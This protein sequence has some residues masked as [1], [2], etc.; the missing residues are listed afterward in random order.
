MR[1]FGRF[2]A[3]TLV[4]LLVV[5]AI[6]G[7]LIG[8]LLPAVQ[9]AREAARRSHCASNLKQ[10]GL[11]LHNYADANRTLC[12]KQGGTGTGEPNFPPPPPQLQ[13][14][15]ECRSGWTSLSVYME[16]SALYNMM[17]RPYD[18]NGDGTMDYMAFG[19]YPWTSSHPGNTLIYVPWVTQIPTI[20]CP[21]DS[22][23]P[24]GSSSVAWTSYAFCCGDTVNDNNAG[25]LRGAFGSFAATT[26]FADI[27][28][29]TSSTLAFG[30]RCVG[31]DP[32]YLASG[33][34]VKSRVSAPWVATDPPI[35]CLN[36]RGAG[37][38]L[39]NFRSNNY[40]GRWWADGR[41][42]MNGFCTILAPN[43]PS[44][45]RSINQNFNWGVYTAGSYH[46][47]GC[48]VALC[49][50]SVRFISETIDTGRIDL[51]PPPNAG[52]GPSPY[53]VWGALGTKNGSEV[54]SDF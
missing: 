25:T 16:Q 14:N 27:V 1:T 9:A 24:A 28:D 6:I 15:W 41:A 18:A 46:P 33:G 38:Q 29:G 32:A 51:P 36:R 7:V 47:G 53:G 39:G 43:S 54:V 50:G 23:R 17:S 11:A 12:F 10:A 22:A 45:M 49:D 52:A 3:F 5:I 31:S 8:L 44:C 48:N 37:G 19:P 21:S 30:E 2:K 26:T 4:E 13:S 35:L 42:A 20:R 34:E 40:A